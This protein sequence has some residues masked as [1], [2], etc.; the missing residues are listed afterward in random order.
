MPT[1][2]TI[3]SAFCLLGHTD[4]SVPNDVEILMTAGKMQRVLTSMADSQ[5]S[6]CPFLNDNAARNLRFYP[7]L[8]LTEQQGKG[9]KSSRRSGKLQFAV[10]SRKTTKPIEDHRCI[11]PHARERAFACERLS[12]S[13][14]AVAQG[15]GWKT[16]GYREIPW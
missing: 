5:R 2:S 6:F 9:T 16:L 3:L 7:P 1:N 4:E 14:Q 10:R 12:H 8:S 15:R 11:L 13:E